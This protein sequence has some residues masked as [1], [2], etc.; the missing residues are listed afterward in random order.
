M[1]KMTH[2]I[3]KVFRCRHYMPLLCR[4]SC[5]ELVGKKHN[6]TDLPG[7]IDPTLHHERTF[8]H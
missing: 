2:N 5:G 6:S 7:G 8:D 4:T 1:V 3:T